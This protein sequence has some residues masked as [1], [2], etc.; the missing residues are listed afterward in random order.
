M[1]ERIQR[2]LQKSVEAFAT[3]VTAILQRAVA[4]AVAEALGGSRAARAQVGRRPRGRSKAKDAAGR[5]TR[6]RV[7]Q[8]AGALLKEVQR[9]GDRRMEEIA[10]SL[11]TSTK[12]L[13]TPMKKLLAAKKVK[14]SGTARGTKYRAA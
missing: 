12:A 2:E 1:N 11:R 6:Q 9:R 4:A 14:K 3:D 7:Q 10:K 5:R 13:V 8:E